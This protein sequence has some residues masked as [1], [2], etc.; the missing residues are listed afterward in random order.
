[1]IC[2]ARHILLG[3]SDQENEKGGSCDTYGGE[4]KCAQGFGGEI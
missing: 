3:R 2:T 1:V 4:G